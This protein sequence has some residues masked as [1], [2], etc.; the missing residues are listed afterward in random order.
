[1]SG[2]SK[3]A[4]S[5]YA[6]H[7]RAITCPGGSD[8]FAV[9]IES[10]CTGLVEIRLVIEDEQTSNTVGPVSAPSHVSIHEALMSIQGQGL[11]E[12]TMLIDVCPNL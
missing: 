2:T 4:L 12:L 7:I 10:R 1:M 5:K 8:L 11:D 9:L 3:E 6:H